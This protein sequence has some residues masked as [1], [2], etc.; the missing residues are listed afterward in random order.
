MELDSILK[1]GIEN[2]NLDETV[3]TRLPKNLIDLPNI[4][5]YGSA[6]TGKYT[7]SLK[8]IKQYSNSELKYSKRLLVSNAKSDMYIKISDIHFEID[9]E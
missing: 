6:G 7:E 9:M 8:L 3:I 5:L 1:S 2:L 4:I